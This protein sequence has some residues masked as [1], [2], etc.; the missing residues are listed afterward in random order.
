MRVAAATAALVVA[1]P[2]TAQQRAPIAIAPGTLQ[3]A[4]AQIA[5]RTGA[6]IAL[7]DPE[8]GML[9]V[10]GLTGTMTAEAALRRAVRRLPVRVVVIDAATFRLVRAPK[11]APVRPVARR[12][13]RA[14]VEAPVAAAPEIIV[15]ATK[16]DPR[17]S[18]HAG[19]IAVIDGA[20]LGYAGSEG[21]AAV[22]RAV[23]SLSSTH[24]GAGRDK[25]FLRGVGDSSYSGQT[26]ATVGQYFGEARLNYTGPDPALRLY[27]IERVELLLG[28][29]GSLYGAGSLG[30]IMRIE[31]NRPDPSGVWGSLLFSGSVT[32]RGAP[33]GEAAAVLNLPTGGAGGAVRA[34]GY[35]L[36]EGGYIDDVGRGVRDSDRLD[37]AGGRLAYA[38]VPAEGWEAELVGLFQD[39]D[40]RDAD[41]ADR[42]YGALTRASAIAQPYRNRYRLGSITVRHKG[43]A[44]ALV[45]DLSR[46]RAALDDRFDGG[47]SGSEPRVLARHNVADVTAGEVRIARASGGP[48]SWVVGAAFV[49]SDST[50]RARLSEG[51][52][53]FAAIEAR[54]STQ[55][56]TLFGEGAQSAGPLTL[57]LG[58]RLV[59]WDSRVRARAEAEATSRSDA[60][61][62]FLPTAAVLFD[63]GRDAQLFVRHARSYRPPIATAAVLGVNRLAGDRYGAWEFGVRLLPSAARPFD[64]SLAVSAGRWRDV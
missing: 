7:G 25:L 56:K 48:S 21:T 39:I 58:L 64:A 57:S 52:M 18:R 43:D 53:R 60:G 61:W 35:R 5:A 13:P 47:E 44:L 8:I 46:S 10:P 63:W 2:A 4:I 30:G 54:A 62:M 41:Y 12:T 23:T 40:A 32:R 24:L 28:A 20:S 37:V 29:Q 45:A 50:S 51:D 31:P 1:A 55:E 42:R 59:R 16:R 14:P 36:R 3:S 38:M 6:S 17:Q 34:V 49:E 33:G 15:T 9:A 26:Q 22:E 19:T 27:D 11:R